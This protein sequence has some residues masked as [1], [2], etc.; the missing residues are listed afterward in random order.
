MAGGV[1]PITA[2]MGGPSA[3]T[4][5]SVPPQYRMKKM[6]RVCTRPWKARSSLPITIADENDIPHDWIAYIKESLKTNIP[7]FST[8]RMVKEYVERLYVKALK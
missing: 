3:R 4:A 2:I 7:Q 8:R 5:I 1:K 6:S